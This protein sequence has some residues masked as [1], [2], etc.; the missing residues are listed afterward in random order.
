MNYQ[1]KFTT[2][3]EETYDAVIEQLKERWGERFV[4]NFKT[5]FQSH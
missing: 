4:T 1:I 5:R 2:E 3:A